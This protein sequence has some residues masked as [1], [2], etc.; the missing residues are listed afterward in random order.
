MV[1]VNVND[2]CLTDEDS[3]FDC[4]NLIPFSIQRQYLDHISINITV[5]FMGAVR[6]YVCERRYIITST[7]G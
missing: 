6:F 5:I 4:Y 7:F 3:V 1:Q 2:V